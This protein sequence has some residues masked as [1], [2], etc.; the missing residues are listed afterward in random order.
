MTTDDGSFMLSVTTTR[1]VRVVYRIENGIHYFTSPDVIG[2]A[3]Y[4][5]DRYKAFE[6]FK[7]L[8]QERVK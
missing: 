2:G 1:K 8:L 4:H 5:R 3:Y 7:K 6:G